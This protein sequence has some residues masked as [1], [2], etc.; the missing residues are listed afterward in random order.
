MNSMK[1]LNSLQSEATTTPIQLPE[2]SPLEATRH[3]TAVQLPEAAQLEAMRHENSETAPVA[4]QKPTN[5]PL[6]QNDVGAHNG[7]FATRWGI[8]RKRPSMSMSDHCESQGRE[9]LRANSGADTDSDPG[10]DEEC[11]NNNSYNR[12]CP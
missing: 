3:T 9:I 11:G 2:A 4:E 10:S 8:H 7:A 1:I 6:P 5:P 12:K